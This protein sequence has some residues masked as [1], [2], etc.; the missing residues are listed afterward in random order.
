MTLLACLATLPAFLFVV[1]VAAKERA[2]A[3]RRAETEARYIADLASREHANQV[4]GARRL[5]LRLATIEPMAEKNLGRL[6]AVLPAI[7]AGFPQFANLGAVTTDG[8]VA[9]SSVPPPPDLNLAQ[10]PA[11]VAALS[12]R[13][14]AV[15]RYQV[16]PIVGRPVLIMAHALRSASGEPQLVLWAA[17]ELAWLD[18]LARQAGLPSEY[19]LFI[20]DRDGG[21][22]A[23]SVGARPAAAEKATAIAG[24]AE[25]TGRP[26]GM[27]RCEEPDGVERLVVASPLQGAKDLWVVAGLPAAAVYSIANRVFY[28]D[29]TVLALFAL[30]G[31]GSSLLATDLSVIRDLRLL[32]LATRRFGEG[33]L[34]VRAPEPRPRGEL[35]DLAHSFNL[36]AAALEARH[37]EAVEAQ[38]N[39]RALS[40]RL[41]H[42]REEEAA[43]IAQELHDELGQELSVLRLEL[44]GLRRRIAVAASPD[45][46]EDL[47]GRIDGLGEMIDTAVES[48]RRISSDLRPGVLDRLGLT[49]G[50]E[51]LL[52]E[53]ERRSSIRT[54]LSAQPALDPVDAE[55]SIALFRI[56]Q[57]ALTNVARHAGARSVSA[58]LR[59]EGDDVVLE[60]EDDGRGFDAATQSHRPSL[61]L[62]GMEERARRLGGSLRIA[63]RL[64]KGTRLRVAIPKAP[65]NA[66]RG[67]ADS[68]GR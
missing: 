15:G 37:Q 68:A 41:Q 46:V 48:V 32:A 24:F 49:A 45:Q 16:G 30:L 54:S 43:R 47:T 66:G 58:E 33:D 59:A 20:A 5:L 9:F 14:V 39:L 2:A 26:S 55:V 62:L 11:F 17:L 65:G 28:R 60:V 25:L 3:L 8:R 57:E 38:E 42:A 13:D 63:S 34:S 12:S 51:W 64:G 35:R 29:I 50:L 18:E 6:P 61:G 4:A 23:Q 21:I 52:K 53:F 27:V 1:Y 36:M 67:D 7:V 56:T 22:L 31:V 40:H 44:D 19:A 10:N